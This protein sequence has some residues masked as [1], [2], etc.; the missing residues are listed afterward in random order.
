MENEKKNQYSFIA[1]NTANR[2]QRDIPVSQGWKK[3]LVRGVLRFQTS[4]DPIEI[5]I[6]ERALRL[7]G[8][9]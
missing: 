7:P 3:S 8:N 4:L 1:S 5:L 6:R 2:G 9:S